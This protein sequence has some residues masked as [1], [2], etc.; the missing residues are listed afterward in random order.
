MTGSRQTPHG[1][2][3]GDDAIDRPSRS[4]IAEAALRSP[5]RQAVADPSAEP[6]I[7]GLERLRLDAALKHALTA[8]VLPAGLTLVQQ[9]MA[10][11]NGQLLGCDLTD[12]G[13]RLGLER[14]YR[15]L[16]RLSATRPDRFAHVDR[17]NDVRPRTL[18]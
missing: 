11:D 4:L 6:D 3:A 12:R 2:G 18:A 7:A 14:S 8:E 13:L 15:A 5:R 1:H 17:A 9:G 10:A 16:A